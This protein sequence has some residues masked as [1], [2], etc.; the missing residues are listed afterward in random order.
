MP[1]LAQQSDCLGAA[2][3]ERDAYTNAHSDRVEFICLQLGLQCNLTAHETTLLRAASRLHDVGK[4]GV[5]DRVLLKPGRLDPEEL[6]VMRTHCQLGQS[7]CDKIPHEDAKT[8]SYLVRCHHEAFD[9]SG[10]P[11]GL[12][13]EKIPLLARII[14]IADSYDAMST[15][16]P[17]HQ[18]RSHTQTMDVMRSECGIKTDPVLFGYFENLMVDSISS[19]LRN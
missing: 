16:R 14:A 1:T 10:Y 6:E 4:I 8:V 7:I 3:A 12:V 18:A 19:P 13:G 15:T 9:G 17:Y 11:D 5:P 2:L